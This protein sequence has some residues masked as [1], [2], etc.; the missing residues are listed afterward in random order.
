MVEDAQFLERVSNFP[1]P[2]TKRWRFCYKLE[3]FDFF[4][5][6]LSRVNFRL[7]SQHFRNC[8][9]LLSNPDITFLILDSSAFRSHIPEKEA[10]RVQRLHELREALLCLRSGRQACHHV[11]Q[12]SNVDGPAEGR[13]TT[14][15]A[16][17]SQERISRR[18]LK[19]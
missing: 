18:E 14:W 5:G 7:V 11:L 15:L 17:C 3:H 12:L 13:Y 2:N 1:C 8:K 4:E 9:T 19:E 10:E 16:D 6:A